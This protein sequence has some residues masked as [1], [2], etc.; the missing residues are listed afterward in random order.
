[1]RIADLKKGDACPGGWAK[2]VLL[3]WRFISWLSFCLRCIFQQT[4]QATARFVG[5]YGDI[6]R[7][8]WIPSIHLHNYA[9]AWKG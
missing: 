8:L 5:R 9:N 4:P 1:M 6:R 7:E 2:L 3:Q